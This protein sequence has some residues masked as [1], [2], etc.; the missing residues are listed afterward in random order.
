[1]TMP[2]DV[3]FRRTHHCG[4]GMASKAGGG[5][6]IGAANRRVEMVLHVVNRGGRRR[7]GDRVHAKRP[8]FVWRR[9]FLTLKLERTKI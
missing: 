6:T 7:L 1:M 9:P 4:G 3:I 8:G 5:C 2:D